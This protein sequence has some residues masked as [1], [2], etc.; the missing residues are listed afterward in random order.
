MPNTILYKEK[1][2]DKSFK[3]IAVARYPA[4]RGTRHQSTAAEAPGVLEKVY[5]SQ[6]PNYIRRKEERLDESLG[7]WSN[8]SGIPPILHVTTMPCR[9]K[10]CTSRT[11]CRRGSQITVYCNCGSA[12][13]WYFTLKL[14]FICSLSKFLI[15]DTNY[16]SQLIS[17]S[18]YSSYCAYHVLHIFVRDSMEDILAYLF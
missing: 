6:L 9:C 7:K 14:E 4:G 17:Q 11:R 16:V 15:L 2:S 3:E 18:D 8:P 13:K 5:Q 1:L 10:G 12:I